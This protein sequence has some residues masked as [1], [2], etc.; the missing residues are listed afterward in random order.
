MI[1]VRRVVETLKVPVLSTP[2]P[3]PRKEFRLPP[4]EVGWRVTFEVVD[5]LTESYSMAVRPFEDQPHGLD[6]K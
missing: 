2:P 3:P 5:S 4:S 6:R 1:L